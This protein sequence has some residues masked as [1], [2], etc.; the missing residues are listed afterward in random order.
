MVKLPIPSSGRTV[1][2]YTSFRTLHLRCDHVSEDDQRLMVG[3]SL[4][5]KGSLMEFDVDHQDI[6]EPK[7]R[8]EDDGIE[9][10]KNGRDDW[11]V[12]MAIRV[13]VA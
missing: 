10:R 1:I 13:L 2:E 8:F 11:T 12:T 3:F 6:R 5:M 9:F 4:A 7:C